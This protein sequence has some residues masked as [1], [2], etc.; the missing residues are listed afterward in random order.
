MYSSGQHFSE[1]TLE[2]IQR[3]VS[4]E[5][6]ISRCELSRRVCELMEWRS[7]NGK[8]QTMSCRKT[9]LDFDRRGILNLPSIEEDF[10]F[11]HPCDAAIVPEIPEI[12]CSLEA[13]DQISVEP[14]T[15]RYSKE[16]KVWFGLLENYH[17]LKS[18]HLCGAQIR[19]IVKSSRYGYL[20]ALAFS[21]ASWALK[22]RDKYIGWTEAAR[23]ANI[24]YVVR[25]DRFLILPSVKV[26][27]LASHLLSLVLSRLPGDWEERY[28][29]RPVLVETFVDPGYFSGICYKAANWKEVGLSSGRRDWIPKK[30]FLYHL[31]DHWRES[32]CAEPE[33]RLGEI[34]RPKSP[35]NWAEK[36]LGT[37]RF[38]DHRLKE[39]LYT[40]AQDFYDSPTANIP[41]ACGSVAKTAGAYR[42]IRNNKVSMDVIL[43]AHTEASIDRIKEHRLV[44]APQDTTTLNYSHHP[45][46]KGLGPINNNNHKAIGLFLHDTMAFTEEGTPL[47]LLDAQCWIRDPNDKG[48]SQR[49]AELPIEQKESVKWLRSYRK[50]A[51]IQ[52]LCPD[53]MLISIGDRESDIYELFLEAAK[54]PGGP[55]L[56]VR[57]DK[58][59]NRKIIE[60]EFLWDFMAGRDLAGKMKI[61]IPH[62]GSRKPRNADLEIRFAKVEFKPPKR[63][64]GP[65]LHAW[66]VYA[67]EINADE[68]VKEPIEWMLYTTV[69][70]TSFQD[71]VQRIEWYS[72]RWGIEVYHRTLKSGCRIKEHQLET[73]D[74]LETCLGLDMVV[75]WR[76]Y[77]LTM[78][79]RETPSVPC[80][81][82]FNEIEW[83]ALY[84]Y[85]HE[86]PIVPDE[87]PTIGEAVEMLAKMGGHIGN[88]R[89]RPVGTEILWR[90]L[91]RLEGAAKMYAFL[92]GD[93]IRPNPRKSGP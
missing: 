7:P 74:R 79:G 29:I 66:A 47:G 73:L 12:K 33:V 90:A 32:L 60:D 15:S 36:E 55:Q 54:Y 14:I 26:K 62:S 51:E 93:E 85:S 77:H 41:E 10:A 35:S 28:N 11:S 30:I 56:L 23:R 40:L 52:K 44:L 82:F 68:S 59:R 17:Y 8:L 53:T 71:A 86:S 50:V 65:S 4:E 72:G 31:C 9:L 22:D 5:P 24:Q 20:G 37:V 69:E 45:T 70:V 18:G 1:A 92:R 67:F 84:C 75:A 16:S 91:L 13:L 78:L 80:T 39:R 63:I 25:N 61:H 42:F 76:I 64:K 19:Y 57:A 89:N 27:N 58:S 3:M 48:K 38:F 34:P 2:T 83:K 49:R 88:I 21:S 81:V 87:P 43:T 46:T 6:T